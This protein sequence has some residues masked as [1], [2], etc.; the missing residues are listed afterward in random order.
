MKRDFCTH[1]P[2][3]LWP[4]GPSGITPLTLIAK[5]LNL[6]VL[7]FIE[8]S[9][10]S[11]KWNPAGEQLAKN[12]NHNRSRSVGLSLS[13]YVFSLLSL[14]FALLS[15]SI[16]V[17]NTVQGKPLK[18]KETFLECPTFVA[19]GSVITAVIKKAQYVRRIDKN[20]ACHGW[21]A[22]IE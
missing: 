11:R 13:F 18:I 15:F 5:R 16:S 12:S 4:L 8:Y 22:K 21:K 2:Q 17:K 3:I 14:F 10:S 19:I 9:H 6:L 1:P 20:E 7:S